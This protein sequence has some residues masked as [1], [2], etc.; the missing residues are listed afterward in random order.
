MEWG[1]R[2]TKE[3]TI[4]LQMTVDCGKRRRWQTKKPKRPEYWV[5]AKTDQDW[6]EM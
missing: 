2:S 5:R 6:Q 4:Q 1:G 3:Q